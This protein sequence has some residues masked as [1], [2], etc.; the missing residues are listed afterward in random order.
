MRGQAADVVGAVIVDEIGPQLSTEIPGFPGG[1][2]EKSAAIRGVETKA[3][4]A[5]A[6]IIKPIVGI[7][8]MRRE[9]SQ[10]LKQSPF[11]HRFDAKNIRVAKTDASQRIAA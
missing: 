3:R 5:I 9:H 8:F 10:R 4:P 11:A 1:V 2:R 6:E 7:Q